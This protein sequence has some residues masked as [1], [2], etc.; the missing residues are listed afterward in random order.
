MTAVVPPRN[1]VT[2]SLANGTPGESRGRKATGPRLL[3]DAVDSARRLEGPTIAEAA[4]GGTWRPPAPRRTPSLADPLPPA[5]PCVGLF[6]GAYDYA[7][8]TRLTNLFTIPIDEL[9][10]VP[11]AEAHGSVS[12]PCGQEACG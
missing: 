7:G 3:R 4:D 9:W 1:S 6:N 8:R 2:L 12:F 11:V 5:V 10:D